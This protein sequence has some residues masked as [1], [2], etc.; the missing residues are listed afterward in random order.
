MWFLCEMMHL[1]LET[2]TVATAQISQKVDSWYR[3]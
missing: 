1:T 3:T 2:A